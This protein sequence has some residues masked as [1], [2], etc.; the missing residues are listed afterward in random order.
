MIPSLTSMRQSLRRSL[1]IAALTLVVF[2]GLA[3]K[4][5][6]SDIT[7]QYVINQPS[8]F[9]AAIY[10]G[11]IAGGPGEIDVHTLTAMG[12]WGLLELVIEVNFSPLLPDLLVVASTLQHLVGPDPGDVNPGLPF[13]VASALF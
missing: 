3:G 4:S 13:V 5:Q 2:L 1:L 8:Y 7:L 10:G 11:P 12:S 6:A 9:A